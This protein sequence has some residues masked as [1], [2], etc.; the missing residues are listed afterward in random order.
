MNKNIF[1]VWR[2]DADHCPKPFLQQP[3]FLQQAAGAQAARI[4]WF[5][6]RRGGEPSVIKL[7]KYEGNILKNEFLANFQIS[8]AKWS[9][10]RH[11]ADNGL[12]RSVRSCLKR[13]RRLLLPWIWW[14]LK[15]WKVAKRIFFQLEP[16]KVKWL[17]RLPFL[18]KSAILTWKSQFSKAMPRLIVKFYFWLSRLKNLWNPLKIWWLDSAF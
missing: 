14:L 10:H 4:S 13:L 18:L 7:S 12:I 3:G 11:V 2:K 6:V 1:F 17:N 9:M 5:F 15:S 16:P 8:M